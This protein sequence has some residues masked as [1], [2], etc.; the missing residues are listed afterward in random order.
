MDNIKRILVISSDHKLKEVLRFCL[1]GWGYEVFIWNE[2][3]DDISQ[4]KKLSPAIIVVDVHSARHS[5]L[6]ICEDLK[7]DFITAFIPVITLINKRHLRSHLLYLK[8]GVDDYL[9][10]PPDPLDLRIRIEMALRRC[11]YN[12]YSSPL[13][14]LPGGRLVE[15]IL[16]ER[17]E[18]SEPFTFAH[19]DID[20]FKTFNDSYGYLMGD[21][22]IM[23]T[24]YMLYGSVKK[25]GDKT[26]FVGHIGGDDFVFIV[27]PDKYEKIASS[28]IETFDRIIPFHYS[29]EDRDNGYIIAKDR[30]KHIKKMPLMSISVAI[31][32]NITK[33]NFKNIIDINIRAVEIKKYLKNISGSAYMSDRRVIGASNKTGPY[34]LKTPKESPDY[35]PLGQMLLKN[36]LIS[37]EQL[38]EALRVHWKRGI[39]LGEALKELGILRQNQIEELLNIKAPEKELGPLQK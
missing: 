11:Q 26:D 12:Y 6:K 1:D 9:I 7:N 28:F 38:N 3:Q 36:K 32:N 33:Q 37:S 35:L 14:G 2:Y 10:K 19:V 21:R 4:I 20:N 39:L 22:V 27:K 5:D 29:K 13:T 17:L 24:A 23:N 30:T 8:H 16:T 18:K 15:D 34:I 31:V 25:F